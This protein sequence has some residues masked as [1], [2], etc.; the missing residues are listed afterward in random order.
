MKTHQQRRSARRPGTPRTGSARRPSR[1]AGSS[2]PS[3]AVGGHG[4]RVGRRRARCRP[5]ASA[6]RPA[7][8][9]A[10]TAARVSELAPVEAPARSTAA[11]EQ[12]GDRRRRRRTRPVPEN[13]PR[14]ASRSGYHVVLDDHPDRRRPRAT[15]RRTPASAPTDGEDDHDDATD[16]QR[17]GDAVPGR[18]AGR[19]R[20]SVTCRHP[21]PSSCLRSANSAG[22]GVTRSRSSS[23]I[24]IVASRVS[25]RSC[26]SVTPGWVPSTSLSCSTTGRGAPGR[27]QAD[28]DRAG[29]PV[30]EVGDGDLL[31]VQLGLVLAAARAGP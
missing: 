11:G 24:T 21:G 16:L 5:A 25:S 26:T 29:R 22:L 7:P 2:V 6:R 27:R 31:A 20:S 15:P 13:S 12:P 4:L 3:S 30:G 14:T 18:R 17:H 19:S 10:T 8:S 28:H 23:R 1:V 9:P